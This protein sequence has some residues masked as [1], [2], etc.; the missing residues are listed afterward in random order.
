MSQ[1]GYWLSNFEDAY[2][3]EYYA[4][5][6]GPKLAVLIAED[7]SP[8]TRCGMVHALPDMLSGE[9]MK[10]M[11]FPRIPMFPH[12]HIEPL[13]NFFVILVLIMKKTHRIT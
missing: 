4:R 12:S 11:Y 6:V 8:G 7:P 3:Q 5:G 13:H 2:P 10:G 9:P 1:Q